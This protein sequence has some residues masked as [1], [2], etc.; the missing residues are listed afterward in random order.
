MSV[1]HMLRHVG[2]IPSGWINYQLSVMVNTLVFKT[3]IT[4]SILVVG[5]YIM[6]K[7]FKILLII[8]I[9]CILLFVRA[10]LPRYKI[11]AILKVT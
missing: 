9:F 1:K 7:L 10:V 4:S 8:I 11:D 6:F 3:N 2:S 5:V